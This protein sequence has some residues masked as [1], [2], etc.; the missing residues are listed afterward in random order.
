MEGKLKNRR[1]FSP[2]FKLLV[3]AQAATGQR[4]VA[5]L[6]REHRIKDSVIAKWRDQFLERSGLIFGGVPSQKEKIES[7]E[8]EIGRQHME[9]EIL[10]KA[11]KRLH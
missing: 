11:S 2:D 8:L 3:A 9:I 4:T 7:L 1:V 5:E 10:K 6:S